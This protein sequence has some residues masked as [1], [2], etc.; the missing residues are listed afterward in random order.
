MILLLCLK[1]LCFDLF[2]LGYCFF[3]NELWKNRAHIHELAGVHTVYRKCDHI[4]TLQGLSYVD[5]GNYIPL[6][7]ISVLRYEVDIH[8]HFEKKGVSDQ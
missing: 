7:L 3:S 5:L 8:V 2:G 6:I 4:F 1:L